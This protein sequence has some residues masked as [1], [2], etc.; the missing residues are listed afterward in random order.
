MIPKEG[1]VVTI[2]KDLIPGNYYKL[3]SGDDLLFTNPMSMYAGAQVIITSIIN[4]VKRTFQIN[5][6][7]GTWSWAP[8]FM[9]S[10]INW[11][12]RLEVKK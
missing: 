8:E 1:D 7:G 2:R 12:K 11:R 6:D 4:P 3:I 5:I 9:V 10:P